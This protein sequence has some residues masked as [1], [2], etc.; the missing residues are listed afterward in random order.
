MFCWKEHNLFAEN[1]RQGPS[2]EGVEGSPMSV[3]QAYAEMIGREELTLERYQVRFFS[4]RH[5]RLSQLS[6]NGQVYAYL[7][8]LG[9]VVTRVKR[10]NPSYPMPPPY[11]SSVCIVQRRS[12]VQMVL[13]P[14]RFVLCHIAILF[15]PSINW[16]KPIRISPLLGINMNYR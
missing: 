9:Y 5:P 12:L 10:P 13:H 3:Q 8:R 7:K 6:Y 14:L 11:P 4:R 2:L 15:F 16:W 1:T